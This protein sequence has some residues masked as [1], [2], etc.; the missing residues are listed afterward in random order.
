MILTKDLVDRSLPWLPMFESS[1]ETMG[2]CATAQDR[3]GQGLI[4]FNL[5]DGQIL[6]AYK[7]FPVLD[8]LRFYTLNGLFAELFGLEITLRPVPFDGAIYWIGGGKV[9]SGIGTARIT[10]DPELFCGRSVIREISSRE[11]SLL[12]TDSLGL[13]VDQFRGYSKIAR[14]FS[15]IDSVFHL[16]ASDPYTFLQL[17]AG[18]TSIFYVSLT[19]MSTTVHCSVTFTAEP[20]GDVRVE[21][22]EASH[23]RHVAIGPDDPPIFMERFYT[24]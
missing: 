1:P 2:R 4:E 20:N 5:P 21:A 3:V 12:F 7:K 10:R 11:Q 13:T 6:E 23:Y 16:I 22:Y 8:M 14:T 15:S 17:G 9:A 18:R 19:I 24:G